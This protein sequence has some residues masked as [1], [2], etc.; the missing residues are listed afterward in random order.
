MTGRI[1]AGLSLAAGLA[2]LAGCTA[3]SPSATFLDPGVPAGALRLVAFD[4]CQQA[5]DALRGAAK[6]AVG[7]YGFGGG[8]GIVAFDAGSGAERKAGP[9]DAAAPGAGVPGAAPGGAP[10]GG[11]APGGAPGQGATKD[12]SSGY[13]GTNTHEAGVDEPDLV[14]T[15]GR[16]IVTVTHGVLRVV[17]AH[18]RELTGELD[19]ADGAADGAV[20]GPLRYA[21]TNLLLAG[22]RAL[23]LVESYQGWRGGPAEDGPV[24]QRLTGPTLLLVDLAG[25]RPRL[26]STYTIDGGLVDARQ[27]G[28]TVRVVVRSTPQLVFPYENRKTDAQRTAANQA[29]IDR[30]GIEAWLP[31]WEVNT[32]GERRSGRVDCAAVSRPA[33]YSGAS[34]LTV[35]TVDLG[36]S[37]LG[38]GDPVTVVADGD[39]VYGTGTTLYVA[40]DQRWRAMPVPGVRDG[41]KVEERTDLYK[42][43]VSGTGRP[44]FAAAGSVPGWLINQYALSEWHGDLRV[45]TTTGQPWDRNT[46][47]ES[48]VY[49]LR[50]R[51]RT[52]DQ[53]G[54]VGGLGKRERIY[55]VRFVGPVGYVV[56][57]RQTDPLYTIDLHDPAHPKAVGELKITGYSAYLHPIGD[58]RLLGIGQEASERGRVQGTQVSLFDVADPAA[59]KRLGQ[60]HVQFGHSEA[61]FDPHAFLYWPDTG[62]LVVPVQLA[63]MAG[64]PVGDTPDGPI[65]GALVLKVGDGAFTALGM[66]TH[67]LPHDGRLS[68]DGRPGGAIHRSLI[69]AG[70]LWT[71]SDVGLKASDMNTLDTK[72]WIPFA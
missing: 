6:A 37:A 43:D 19:L 28:A 11:A 41:A 14:K 24:Q 69:A 48:S 4:S 8:G 26:V 70:A 42:F 52:L 68:P 50:Q 51:G 65:T 71:V 59:P 36:Q 29:V 38:S 32:G 21:P 46:V 22:D 47:S 72:R 67:P 16:R 34:M 33:N 9:P 20:D 7:P 13:S 55:A 10:G 63:G 64:R 57:F 49:V 44:R 17:D 35:L 18:S 39:T 45:A 31:R 27:V 56:T 12:D 3:K 2:L 53:V 58:N 66:V 62:L 15:D 5:L 1:R 54:H 30:A 61:E 25:G 23:V 60:Y 40:N